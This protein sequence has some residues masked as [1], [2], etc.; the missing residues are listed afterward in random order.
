MSVKVLKKNK[1]G[2]YEVN[3]KPS[4]KELEDYYSLKYYQNPTVP[5]YSKKYNNEELRL[6]EISSEVADWVATRYLRKNKKKLFDIGCGEGFFMNYLHKMG[7]TVFGTDYSKAGIKRMNPHLIDN[8][9][10]GNA[11]KDIDLR[12]KNKNNYT[13]VNL[14]NILEHVIDPIE[15]LR[16]VKKLISKD[17]ILR[18]VVP[19]DTSQFQDLLKKLGKNNDEWFCP[20]DHLS[21]FNFDTLVN[22]VKKEG[23]DVVETFGDFPIE[24]FLLNDFSNY[25]K[26][27]ETGRQAH[28]A[29][30]KTVN[31]IR[32]QGLDN[33][34]EW[35]KTNSRIKLSRSCIIYCKINTKIES[36][37][38]F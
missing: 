35:S 32:D 10:F 34:I 24:I 30:V 37:N 17:G 13:L 12:I 9:T 38:S 21:Y 31:F 4:Q 2:F 27:K 15:F 25:H 11:I 19:N 6:I 29:R 7:W 36:S 14:G 8:V 1:Y 18:I 33:Y 16:K 26:N 28:L 20:P 22:F 3:P 23:F 5:T